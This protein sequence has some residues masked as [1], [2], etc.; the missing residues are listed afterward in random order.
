VTTLFL[1]LTIGALRLDVVDGALATSKLLGNNAVVNKIPID[2]ALRPILQAVAHVVFY[3]GITLGTITCAEF[4]PKL[5]SPGRVEHLLSLPLKRSQ[6]IVGTFIGVWTLTSGAMLYAATGFSLILSIKT[7]VVI[8]GPIVAALLSSLA[9]AA[10]YS[11]MLVTSTM[12]RS[13]ALS[14]T[15]GLCVL[16]GGIVASHRSSIL[17]LFSPGLGKTVVA[18]V[19]MLFPKISLLANLSASLASSEAVKVG[20]AAALILGFSAFSAAGLF[21]ATLIFEQKDF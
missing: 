13:A 15:V 7:G 11:A 20:N 16:F 18:L 9:W 17:V 6:V 12:V 1:L 4:A 5:M 3:G 8:A 10:I 19:T 2:V 21:I 14:A